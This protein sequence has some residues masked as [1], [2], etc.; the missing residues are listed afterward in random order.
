MTRVTT[1]MLRN[2]PNRYTRDM[3]INRL[4]NRYKGTYDFVYL[5]ID[6]KSKVN[7][8]YAFI[9]FREPVMAARFIQEFHGAKTK[10]CLPG[11]SSAKICEVSYARV[12]GKEANLENLRDEKFI[13]KLNNE[14][15]EWQ[16]LFFDDSGREIPFSKALASTP[17][18]PL[19]KGSIAG[20]RLNNERPEW[21]PLFLDDK[22]PLSKALGAA[23]GKK[24]RPQPLFLDDSINS[25]T[26]GMVPPSPL[27]PVTPSVSPAT[28]PGVFMPN[29]PYGLSPACVMSPANGMSFH[30]LLITTPAAP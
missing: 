27:A 28:P 11:F 10:K 3:L 16:P 19:L 21:Q 24:R 30:V 15:P 18:D 2:I 25:M 8:G 29:G 20:M 6:F 14:R 9:N 23:A 13:Q 1:V 12:Q 26:P 4:N 5:P 17:R 7:V 22:V